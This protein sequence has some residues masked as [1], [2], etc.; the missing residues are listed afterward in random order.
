MKEQRQ[1][2]TTELLDLYSDLAVVRQMMIERKAPQ[3][4]IARVTDARLAVSWLVDHRD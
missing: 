3:S 4:M 1:L 2:V